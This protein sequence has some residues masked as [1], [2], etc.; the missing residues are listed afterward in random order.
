MLV[1]FFLCQQ[2][3]QEIGYMLSIDYF[4]DCKIINFFYVPKGF[5]YQT[6]KC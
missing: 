6:Y 1:T 5:M 2:Y 3:P 4:A